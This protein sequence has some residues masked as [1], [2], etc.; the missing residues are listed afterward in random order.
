MNED[1]MHFM[2]PWKQIILKV[3]THNLALRFAKYFKMENGT[4]Y[5]TLLKAVAIRF[6]V[7]VNGDVSFQEIGVRF[8]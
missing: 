4:E 6:D 3:H 1:R 7:M 8:P 5:R 2:H